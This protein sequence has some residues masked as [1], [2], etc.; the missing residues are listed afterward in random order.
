MKVGIRELKTHLSSYIKSAERG[1][2]IIVTDNGVPIA[3]IEPFKQTELPATFR[4][5]VERGLV[6]DKGPPRNLPQPLP[7]L[8][9]GR[10]LADYVVE[11]RDADLRR[12]ERAG[13]TH[14]D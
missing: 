2:T 14:S 9:G 13:Q 5:L 8:A 4:R 3:R 7:S 11:E 1:E 6:A 10:Q 12:F